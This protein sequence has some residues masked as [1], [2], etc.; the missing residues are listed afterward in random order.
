MLMDREDRGNCYGVASSISMT[1]PICA[2]LVTRVHQ[3]FLTL[4]V[5]LRV[6]FWAVTVLLDYL[7][8]IDSDEIVSSI[9]YAGL[10]RFDHLVLVDAEGRDETENQFAT[11][12]LLLNNRRSHVYTRPSHVPLELIALCSAS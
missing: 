2:H 9:F 3:S 12:W 10:E 5:A 7:G 4:Q 11:D 8:G 1:C 6:W